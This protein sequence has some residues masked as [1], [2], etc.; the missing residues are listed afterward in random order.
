M[1][2]RLVE[3]SRTN[4]SEAFVEISL[5]RLPSPTPGGAHNLKYR[6]ALVVNGNVSCATTTNQAAA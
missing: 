1:K 5:W 2:A 6:L 3:K 4:L